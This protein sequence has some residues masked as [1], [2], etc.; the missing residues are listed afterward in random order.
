MEYAVF[1][2]FDIK[3]IPQFFGGKWKLEAYMHG[4]CATLQFSLP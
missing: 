2:L 4:F 3:A 1:D